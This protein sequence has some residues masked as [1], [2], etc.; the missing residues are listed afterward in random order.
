LFASTRH[1]VDGRPCAPFSLAGAGAAPFVTLR[2]MLSLTFL[3]TRI[4]AFVSAWHRESFSQ[5]HTS[6]LSIGYDQK[7]P[8]QLHIAFS[9]LATVQNIKIQV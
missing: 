3:F 7:V 5:K 9:A 8:I 1:F 4:A 6:D 2:D